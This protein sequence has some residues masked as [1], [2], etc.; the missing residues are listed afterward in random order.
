MEAV[1]FAGHQKLD[2]LI[3]I[4]DSNHVTLDA[5]AEKTQS[6]NTAL[7]FKAI[8]LGRADRGRPRHGRVPEGLQPGEEGEERQAAAHH[9]QDDHR[10][11]HPRGR[12]AP[13]RATARAGAKFADSAARGPRPAGRQALLRERRR[14]R[15]FRRRT[16]SRLVRALQA[17]GQDLTRPGATRIPRRRRSSTRRRPGRAPRTSWRRSRSSR[18]T[19]SSA[20]RARRAAT[21]SSRSRR[22]SR[23]SSAAA[24]TSTARRSTTSP[25]TRISTRPTAPGRNIRFG[26]R[27]HGMAAIANGIAYDGLFRPSVRDVPR[28]RG[29]FAAGDAPGGAARSCPSSTST[30][31]T[32]SASA[33]TARPT[34]RSRRSRRCA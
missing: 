4:Y 5:M 18:R 28:L 17:L 13:R 23:S 22:S 27:E 2:N 20:A 1:E 26:I 10:Q 34:S 31:T 8:E 33:R 14:A 11:G 12:R 32:R 19:P 30:R 7:R 3:L 24:P 25:R 6:E 29:L 16:S 21:C 15:V 9:R